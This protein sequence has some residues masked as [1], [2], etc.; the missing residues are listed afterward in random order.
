MHA[1]QQELIHVAG[2]WEAFEGWKRDLVTALAEDRAANPGAPPIPLW[3]FSG[4]PEYSVEPVPPEGGQPMRYWWESSHFTA[5]LGDLVVRRI[6]GPPSDGS[7]GV[8]LTAENLEP[9]LQRVREERVRFHE[10][11]PGG[12]RLVR[13]IARELRVARERGL[14]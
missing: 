8:L 4:Y 3:D 9:N 10:R 1:L 5:S 7:L 11:E 14:Y 2:L 12:V 6:V 13:V